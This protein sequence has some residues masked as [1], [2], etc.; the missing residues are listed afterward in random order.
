M[1]WRQ[2]FTQGQ[3]RTRT[4]PAWADAVGAD[5]VE[6]I[7]DW[8]VTD[9]FH[10]KQGRSTGRLVLNSDLVVYLKRHWQ[11]PWWHRLLACFHPTGNW[12]PAAQEWENLRSAQ[13]IG[14]S[15]PEPLAM[16]QR[17][18]PGLKLQSFLVIRELTGML[19]LH[20][21][22]PLAQSIMPSASFTRWK[23]Q[24]LIQVA[25]MATRL[26]TTHYY[27]K[28]LYLCHYY[29]K[30]PQAMD[31]SPGPLTL[32]DLHRLGYHRWTAW[33][34]QNKDMAQ[35]LFSTLGVAGLDGH[36]RELILQ[37]YRGNKRQTWL[38]RMFEAMVR[39]KARRYARHNSIEESVPRESKGKAA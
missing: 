19:P 20:Q 30:T 13:S 37:A 35:L 15:V 1:N 10:S 24:L 9:D 3:W 12:T 34:W 33:R 39:L 4:T 26:H 38:N 2:R 14:V 36:D 11:L 18:G 29:V 7:M 8:N 22:I 27:H 25:E 23:N 31:Q 21:A 17:V 6:T 32:I 28:D 5:F 16:G